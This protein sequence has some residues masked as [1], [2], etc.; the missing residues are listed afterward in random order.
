MREGQAPGGVVGEGARAEVIQRRL[1][2]R[3]ALPEAAAVVVEP[4]R[5]V[6]RLGGEARA[7]K[8]GDHLACSR[9]SPRRRDRR[10]RAPARR[11]TP[12][13]PPCRPKMRHRRQQQLARLGVVAPH[14]ELGH[15]DLV[16]ALGRLVRP[17]TRPAARRAR[18]APRPSGGPWSATRRAAGDRGPRDC[19]RRRRR[20]R[21]RLSL[22]AG[23][24]GAGRGRR[25]RPAQRLV[26]ERVRGELAGDRQ[27]L[28]LRAGRVVRRRASAIRNRAS[29]T[30][31]VVG[32]AFFSE[33]RVGLGRRR[34]IALH[35]QAV[36]DPKRRHRRRPPAVRLGG[37]LERRARGPVVAVVELALAEQERR[38]VVVA[39]L[40]AERGAQRLGGVVVVAGAVGGEAAPEV[41][42]RRDG[43]GR[44]AA[45]RRPERDR[46]ADR[47][48]TPTS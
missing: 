19:S 16:V 5:Q 26:G 6:L 2:R 25:R 45:L 9:R 46:E 32:V 37:P 12:P 1:Q 15:P 34:A 40:L 28:L 36:G 11:G 41:R 48:S 18:P 20:R 23:L 43:G 17:A 31:P 47:R 7:R 22:V 30:S 27:E 13:R 42:R 8:L 35:P 21:R 24:P 29:A 39:E 10:A 33:L 38:P 44:Q 3:Q 4:A 14:V